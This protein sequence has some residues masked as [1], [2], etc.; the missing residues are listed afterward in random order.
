MVTATL[1]LRREVEESVHS[2]LH[3]CTLMPVNM[4]EII[5][6]EVVKVYQKPL[7]AQFC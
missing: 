4:G 7:P 6:V 2:L 5:Y 3:E 1:P